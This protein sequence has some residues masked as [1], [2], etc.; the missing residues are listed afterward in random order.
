[1]RKNLVYFVFLLGS[2]WFAGRPFLP[3]QQ[4][5]ALSLVKKAEGNKRL[6]RDEAKELKN[7]LRHDINT[8]FG[9]RNEDV[10]LLVYERRTGT[11]VGRGGEAHVITHATVGTSRPDLYRER[12]ARV[13]GDAFFFLLLMQHVDKRQSSMQGPGSLGK[14]GCAPAGCTG[15]STIALF[16]IYRTEIV[17]ARIW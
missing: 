15:N 17:V 9:T 12:T 1:M 2:T 8:K 10:A 6:S 14:R 13:L 11:E 5:Q 4:L 7:D 16:K 3:P